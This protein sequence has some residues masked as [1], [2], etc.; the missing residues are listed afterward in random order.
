MNNVVSVLYYLRVRQGWTKKKLSML[1]GL[2]QNDLVRIERGRNVRM[3]K[4]I[5]LSKYFG[6]PLSVLLDDNLSATLHT[7]TAPPIIS[8]SMPERISQRL[9]KDAETGRKG[10]EWV[11]Q[12]EVKKL[13][14][15]GLENSVNPNFADDE[16]AHFDILSFLQNG[17]PLVI[18]VKSTTGELDE[19]FYFTADE[20]EKAK[21]CLRGGNRYEVHRV[22]YIDNP[23]KCNR[24]IISA[25]ELLSEYDFKPVSYRVTKK[26]GI[27][28]KI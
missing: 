6:L 24:H 17:I 14:G 21:D 12:Q 22:F 13:A 9:E 8:R 4:Y 27:G 23:E 15:T 1:T 11:Y 16:S 2:S 28:E 19:V 5:T 20:L 10:E 7:F 3:G 26:K 25:E 18:E